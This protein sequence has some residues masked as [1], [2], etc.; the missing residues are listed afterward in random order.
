MVTGWVTRRKKE[1]AK[2][3]ADLHKEIAK[4]EAAAAKASKMNRRVSSSQ[5]LRRVSSVSSAPAM[6]D[7]GF[8]EITR[9]SM[10]K[11]SSKLDMMNLNDEAASQQPKS[12]PK[13]VM[14]RSQSQPAS[15][16]SY[17]ST[18][19][20]KK[21][22]AETLSPDKCSDKTKSMLKEYFVGG[23]SD[24]AVL[25]LH[26]MIQSGSDGSIER[27]AKAIEG[28]VFLVMEMKK[29]H[30]EKC[31]AVFCRAFKEGKLPAE[32]IALGLNDPLEFLSDI[33]IDAPL[34]G[35]H[36]AYIIAELSKLD[37]VQ[38]KDLLQAA[39]EYFKT[40]GKAATFC[41][42]VLKAKGNTD[43]ST[44]DLDFIDSLMTDSDKSKFGSSKE[45][46]DDAKV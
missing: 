9:G 14:R 44:N 28:G 33:E 26:E 6:D 8:V 30:A 3:I 10:K 11:V 42:K 15:M 38:V 46:F 21:A 35:S 36:L 22:P 20:A 39:P 5:N 41:S 17:A 29:E 12:V 31:A 40:D 23:D 2:N 43:P 16:S 45:L 7:D 34:A 37:A 32:S 24:D 13:T 1:T 19:P 27:G 4:E 25:T 18:S